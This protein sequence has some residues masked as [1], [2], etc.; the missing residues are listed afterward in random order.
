VRD[1]CNELVMNK[2]N[3]KKSES[4]D[5][6]T[7]DDTEK[8]EEAKDVENRERETSFVSDTVERRAEEKFRD[9]ERLNDKNDAKKCEN[10]EISKSKPSESIAEVKKMDSA[11]KNEERM[12]KND[13]ELDDY[14]EEAKIDDEGH[15]GDKQMKLD[16]ETTDLNNYFLDSGQVKAE[17]EDSASGFRQEVEETIDDNV[18]TKMTENKVKKHANKENHE[19]GREIK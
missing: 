16:N 11:Q 6:K 8:C 9:C 2:T 14:D 4:D 15:E 10:N 17:E 19:F 7:L 12:K 1:N 3:V 13:G 18:R 5:A